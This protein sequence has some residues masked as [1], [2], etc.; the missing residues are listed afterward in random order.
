MNP[1]AERELGALLVVPI[2]VDALVLA[3]DQLM[4]N[5]SADFSLLPYSDGTRDVNPD[6]ANISEN[7]VSRPL[8][9]ATLYLK[10]GVHLHWKLPGPLTRGVQSPSATTFPVVP[11]RWL[12]ARGRAAK[13]GSR[14]IDQAWVVESDYVYPDGQ[15]VDLGAVN[16]PVGPGTPAAGVR[17]YRY[18]GRRIE[19]VEWLS[20]GP[21]ED[22]D[23]G[24][25][26]IGYP[27][28]LTAVGYGDPNFASFYPNCRS[29][30]G[31]YDAEAAAE[32]AGLTYDV[33][34][35]YGDPA[36]DFLATLVAGLRADRASDNQ[37]PFT[38]AE[39]AGAV[40]QSIGWTATLADGAPFPAGM[41]CAG[42]VRFDVATVAENPDFQDTTTTVVLANTG[43]E[44]LSALLARQIQSSTAP[45]LIEDQLEAVQLASFLDHRQLD[46]GAKFD[47]ARHRKGFLA[48]SGGTS[49]SIRV[50]TFCTTSPGTDDTGPA[51]AIAAGQRVQIVLPEN[52]A[53][54]LE[55]ANSFQQEYNQA[56]DAVESLRRQTFAD[57]YKF[58]LCAYPPDDARDDYPDIDEV[59][60]FIKTHDLDPLAAAIAALGSLPAPTVGAVAKPG[61]STQL[62]APAP[63]TSTLAAQLEDALTAI[64]TQLDTLNKGQQACAGGARFVL[65]PVPAPRYWQPAEPVVL[66][67]GPAVRP[68]NRPGKGAPLPCAILDLTVKALLALPLDQLAARLDAW[69]AATD[70]DPPGLLRW[71]AQPWSPFLLQWEVEVLPVAAGGNLD[72]DSETYSPDFLS[73]NFDL[74]ANAPDLQL[75]AGHGGLTK[76]VNIYVGQS[77]LTPQARLQLAEQLDD[78]LNDP[79]ADKTSDAYANLTAAAKIVNDPAFVCLSQALGGFND[80]LLMH[81][82]TKQLEIDDPLGFPLDRA[83]GRAVGQAVAKSYTSA[84]QPE[85]DFNPIR[86]GGLR[87]G[88]LRL[89]D[90]FGR[91]KDIDVKSVVTP[92]RL[93]MPGDSDQDHPAGAQPAE[94]VWLPPRLAQPARLNFRWL[95]AA[96][97]IVEMNDH[98]ATSPIC[99]W[100]LPNNLDGSLMVYDSDGRPLGIIDYRASWETTPGGPDITPD[101]IA[102]VH[103]GRVVRALTAQTS[104]AADFLS[105]FLASVDSALDNIDPENFA[106]HAD[107]A[108]LMGRPVAVARA[109]LGLELKGRP[110]VH[111]AWNAFRQDLRR[112]SRDIDGFTQ[113]GVPIRIGEFEQ[114]NDGLVGY[115]IETER[116]DGFQDETFFAPQSTEPGHTRIQTNQNNPAPIVR[117]LIDPPLS[118]T[119]LLDPRGKVHATCGILPVKAI[120][121]PPEQYA[122]ALSAIEVVFLSTPVVTRQGTVN[123]PVPMEE[124]YSWSWVDRAPG[125][126]PPLARPDPQATLAGPLEIREGWLK[127][128]PAPAA[129]EPP[130]DPGPKIAARVP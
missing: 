20:R 125:A 55:T 75:A 73:D 14:V 25:A 60:Q 43:T 24:L 12:V 40:A 124:G 8:Q 49:W 76:A 16:I 108:L 33:V 97:G 44:A 113:V 77:N 13:D 5:A 67:S 109:T 7:I 65:S 32:L 23:S 17:P 84:P 3:H 48:V 34:G 118:L 119:I 35:W 52:L 39:L 96:A 126:I 26:A 61:T 31:L 27:G 70:A 9:D 79:R 92:A 80:A 11:N 36:D 18:L 4:V 45:E 122:A 10:A 83:F 94:L 66:L 29:V 98:P 30:F 114:F 90:G 121:I 53:G 85:W 56:V 38:D 59:R 104:D 81:M 101:Q 130:A 1:W 58:M 2:R 71:I 50:D 86:T 15:S 100:L 105:A 62:D 21:G 99:G 116:G 51:D 115:W 63:A 82:Q 41:V 106:Q 88:Q 64:Q 46:V 47:E 72:P 129:A 91:F 28:G 54:L 95:S 42:R 87:L 107:L 127:L 37:A 74:P 89:V 102:D 93:E 68:L 117:T 69:Y 112:L 110:S 78:Y 123:I 57:W 103:L 128:S 6:V 120:D 19:L 111:Q 22:S